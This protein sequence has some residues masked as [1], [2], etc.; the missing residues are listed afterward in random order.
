[1]HHFNNFRVANPSLTPAHLLL[2]NQHK[3][4]IWRPQNHSVWKRINFFPGGF[5][6]KLCVGI[7][8]KSLPHKS[9]YET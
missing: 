2:R 1:M 7:S 9:A 5:R 4:R 6:R 8:G 3:K